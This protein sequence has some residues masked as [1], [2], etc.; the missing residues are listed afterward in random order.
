MDMFEEARALAVTMKMRKIS[1][2]QMAKN[3]GVSQS[4]VANK[5]RLLNLDSEMQKKIVENRLTERHARAILRLKDHDDRDKLLNR[6]CD[7]KLSVQRTEALAD[8]MLMSEQPT[9]PGRGDR[10]RIID[11]F[12]DSTKRS[13]ESIRA[14]GAG[15][16][17]KISYENNKV[18]ISICIDENG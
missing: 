14:C 16:S 12:I 2:G 13:L 11:A 10:L 6:V 15:A 9:T 18:Y 3:L 8:L 5:L 4:F 1:Q 7:E 17:S